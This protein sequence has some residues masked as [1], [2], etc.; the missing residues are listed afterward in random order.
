[1]TKYHTKKTINS[2]YV[3]YKEFVNIKW[4]LFNETKF[5]KFNRFNITGD[6]QALW[7]SVKV[8]HGFL[9]RGN[10]GCLGKARRSNPTKSELDTNNDARSHWAGIVV[11]ADGLK[12][13]EYLF[14]AWNGSSQNVRASRAPHFD[15]SVFLTTFQ[16]M[17]GHP[18]S[19]SVTT[20]F[21]NNVSSN[22]WFSFGFSD[23]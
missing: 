4:R 19:C 13:R 2:K 17:D 11:A 22:G 1:M 8:D 14:D 20:L 5:L 18:F 6:T 3:K 15:F 10:N 12:C 21:S 9:P 23:F 16:H 7:D